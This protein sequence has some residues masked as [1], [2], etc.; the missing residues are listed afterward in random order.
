MEIISFLVVSWGGQVYLVWII[1][2][3][4]RKYMYSRSPILL[5]TQVDVE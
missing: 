4:L 2:H 5:L 1:G 3:I